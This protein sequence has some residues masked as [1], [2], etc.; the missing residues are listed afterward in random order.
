MFVEVYFLL[1]IRIVEDKINDIKFLEIKINGDI[2][3]VV[4]DVYEENKVVLLGLDEFKIFF[5]ELNKINNI[6]I[7]KIIFGKE[8]D[9]I[10]KKKEIEE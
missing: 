9:I 8:E 3:M 7:Y 2:V 4:V 6:D 5:V 10:K 1:S